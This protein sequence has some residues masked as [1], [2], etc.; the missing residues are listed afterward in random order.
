MFEYIGRE[1]NEEMLEGEKILV[2][3]FYASYCPF[4]SKF[5]QTLKKYFSEERVRFAKSDIS[6]DNSPYWSAYNIDVVPT[7]IVFKGAT[8]VDRCDGVLGKGISEKRL[9]ELLERVERL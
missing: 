6:D 2:V 5:S 9:A 3:V 7:V 4:C 8:V 1:F